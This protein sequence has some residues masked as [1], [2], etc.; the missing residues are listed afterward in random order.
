MSTRLHPGRRALVTERGAALL[1]ALVSVAVLTA[2]A[3][4]LAY[5]SRVSLNIAANARD[6]L[7]AHYLARS[8]VAMGR[9]VLSFQQ[10]LDAA[11]GQTAA[12][13]RVQL[14]NLVPVDQSLV[15][16]LFSGVPAA[17]SKFATQEQRPAPGGARFDA[18]IDDEGR[19]VNAQFFGFVTGTDQKLRLR[20]QSL[21]QLIC[22]S[23]WDTL[24]DRED[25]NGQRTTR[26][27]LLVRLRDYVND[28]E[29]S[30]TLRIGGGASA[31]CGL[32]VSQPPFEDAFGDRNQPYDRGEERYKVKGSAMDSLDELYLVAGIGDA[33][34]AAFGDSLTVYLR[35]GDGLNVN[36][37]EK[38]KLLVA[39][40]LAANPPGQPALLDPEFANRLVKL[41]RERTLNGI[42]SITP[43]ELGGLIAAAGVTVNQNLLEG[44]NSPF[45]DRSKV[46]RIRATGKAGIVRSSIDAVVR[47]EEQKRPGDQLAVP[48][49]VI[50]W[51]EE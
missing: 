21:Y 27:D 38:D 12:I 26:E 46:F 16:G 51:R 9:L 35:S 23:R 8:G 17:P 29:R 28:V 18:Q 24:F 39:A 40:G 2:L 25:A 48:G 31:Q 47:L 7:R 33:F 43:K 49:Q 30:S 34:M 22:D 44:P 6:E 45:T 3:V 13:P 36:T 15:D 14:W 20:V 5:Q 4:D 1:S 50:H 10:K 41:V 11:M 37:T 42:L 32:L 19:K